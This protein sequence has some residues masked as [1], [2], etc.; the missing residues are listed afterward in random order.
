MTTEQIAGRLVELCRKGDYEAA[1]KE[2]YSKDA[3]SI[4]PDSAQEPRHIKGLDAIKEKGKQFNSIVEEVHGGFVS[5]PV[6]AG[7]RFSV[8]MG[9]DVTLKGMGRNN[10][11]EI[12]VYETKD[13]KITKEQFFF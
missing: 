13:G 7:S 11:N 9:M 2:L 1:H 10:M 12:C 3:E 6:I 5:D 8:A 4:E